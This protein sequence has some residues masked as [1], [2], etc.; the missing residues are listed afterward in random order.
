MG[1]GAGVVRHIGDVFGLGEAMAGCGLVP[2][3]IGKKKGKKE[4]AAE[5]DEIEKGRDVLGCNEL[6]GRSSSSHAHTPIVV[7]SAKGFNSA[8]TS[9]PP[10]TRSL[11]STSLNRVATSYPT[12][13][14]ELQT[15]FNARSTS[16]D[17]FTA[18][19]TRDLSPSATTFTSAPIQK[20]TRNLTTTPHPD[21][22]KSMRPLF[23]P[24]QCNQNVQSEWKKRQHQSLLQ[25]YTNRT[26]PTSHS[27]KLS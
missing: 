1:T 6:G 9:F 10:M 21:L 2:G 25:P 13:A 22:A 19:P 20:S 3:V 27:R 4:R 11:P 26:T 16:H 8:A 17:P 7:T 23:L 15:R 18:A 14:S 12:V 5:R 24:T